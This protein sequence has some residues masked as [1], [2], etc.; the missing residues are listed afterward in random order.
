[1]PFSK[2]GKS[3][4]HQAR[5]TIYQVYKYMSEEAKEAKSKTFTKEYFGKIFGRIVKATGIRDKSVRKIVVEKKTPMAT[6]STLS[7]TETTIK[8]STPKKSARPKLSVP[9][10]LDDYDL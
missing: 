5:E 4:R 1:M 8:L 9:L 7:S 2:K 10:N 3:I 6:T